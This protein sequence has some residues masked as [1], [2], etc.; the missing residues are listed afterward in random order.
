MEETVI[1]LKNLT[2]R[3]KTKVR[4]SGF[5]SNLKTIFKSD[6][7]ELTAVNKLNLKI[8][9]G[10]LVG[11]IGPNGAGKSTT[12]K[13]LS[14]ILY[15][16]EGSIKILGLVPQK[17]RIKLLYQ[18]GTIFG[19][20]QQLW[21]HLTP[22]DSFY[23]FRDIYEIEKNEFNNRL[24]ELI[25]MFEIDRY[26][27]T[28]VRKLSLGERMRCELVA[29]LLH[30][31][32][33]LFLDEP[34]IGMDIIAKKKLREFVK[35]INEKEKTTILL[36]SHDLDDIEQLCSRVV[37]INHG[38]IIHDSPVSSIKNKLNCKRLEFFLDS[39][40]DK[41]KEMTHTKIVRK[42]KYM[43]VIEVDKSKVSLRKVIDHYFS[44]H[45][46]E[47]INIIDPPIEE[48]IEAFYRK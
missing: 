1:E 17:N 47:D 11:F 33:I 36:T 7:K 13:M 19:Q 16:S 30:K 10:E 34:T 21:F 25:E 37:I 9:R 15:P 12:I 38:K 39:P 44:R 24:K 43:F 27:D 29:A 3:F 20:K 2:K 41:I 8:K 18:I 40:V 42:E 32:K 4:K 5:L 26:V 46:V 31:P 22:M 14:G 45:P 6:Y 48:I 35:K 23:L 28:P